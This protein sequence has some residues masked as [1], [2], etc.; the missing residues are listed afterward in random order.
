MK[1]ISAI[2]LIFSATLFACNKVQD[3]TSPVITIF[4]PTST[5]EFNKD[6]V[7]VSFKVE[8]EDLHEVGFTINRFG[9]D[10]LFYEIPMS[11]AHDNPLLFLDTLSVL[12]TLH[13]DYVLK[14]KAEDHEGN[15]S[16]KT[17]A[18]FHIHN[19]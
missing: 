19:H 7:I 1:K 11:H 5:D 6:S 13:A 9:D 3:T 8:D 15:M 2:I 18:K 12:P 16:T 14:I 4:R 10:S 17:S